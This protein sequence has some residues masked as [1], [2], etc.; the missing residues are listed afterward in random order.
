MTAC[1]ICGRLMRGFGLNLPGALGVNSAHCSM[2]CLDTMYALVKAGRKPQFGLRTAPMRAAIDYVG[3]WI[4]QQPSTDLATY[5]MAQVNE[6]VRLVLEGYC[7]AAV[8][9]AERDA[10]LPAGKPHEPFAVWHNEDKSFNA[11][12][13]AG[14][15]YLQ[16]Q[17][18]SDLAQFSQVQCDA[19]VSAVIKAFMDENDADIPF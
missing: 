3:P 13:A 19:F 10:G 12:V 14:G 2:R 5:T 8:E 9:E 18:T 15:A 6:L 17:P 16:S 4:G 1:A 7:R 11:A